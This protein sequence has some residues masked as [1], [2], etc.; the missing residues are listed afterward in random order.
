MQALHDVFFILSVEKVLHDIYTATE[1]GSMWSWSKKKCYRFVFWPQTHQ[2]ILMQI[3]AAFLFV[4]LRELV[5]VQ[6]AALCHEDKTSRF[7]CDIWA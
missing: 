7:R 3:Y 6:N 2:L 4:H 1:Y 5:P